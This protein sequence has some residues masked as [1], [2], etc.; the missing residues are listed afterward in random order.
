VIPVGIT[1]DGVFVL[2]DDDPAKFALDAERLPQVV[3]N[4]TRIVW[5]E[6]G[7]QRALR[8]RRARP[9]EGDIAATQAAADRERLVDDRPRDAG[10]GCALDHDA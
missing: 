4:G 3:N 2:E 9:A 5:P 1:R 7:F 10:L 6:G 8:V